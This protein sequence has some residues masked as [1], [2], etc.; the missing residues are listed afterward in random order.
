MIESAPPRDAAEAGRRV[1]RDV[2]AVAE[3][4]SL[5]SAGARGG[6]LAEALRLAAR[7]LRAHGTQLE[8]LR[9]NASYVVVRSRPIAGASAPRSCSVSR[10]LLD[11]L[12]QLMGAVESILIESRCAGRGAEWCLY[13]V[14]LRSASDLP[15]DSPI[16]G[17]ADDDAGPATG[18]EG[19]DG[20]GV[21]ST[22]DVTARSLDELLAEV[23]SGE[24]PV[25]SGGGAAPLK[26][27]PEVATASAVES[28]VERDAPGADGAHGGAVHGPHLPARAAWARR[29]AWPAAAMAV[30]GLLG[31]VAADALRS[32]SATATT[33]L[34]VRSGATPRSPGSAQD[35]AQ[36]AV[37]YAALIP[38]DTALAEALG[39]QLGTSP[40][41]ARA[42]LSVTALS[43]TAL[44]SLSYSAPKGHEAVA[45]ARAA[46]RLLTR[47]RPPGTALV[48]GSIAVVSLPSSAS[49]GSLGPKGLLAG[50]LAGLF[51]GLL[52]ILLLERVDAR[53]D[54]ATDLS[55][56]SGCPATA[57]PGAMSVHELSAA[58][59]KAAPGEAVTFV[60]TSPPA[61]TSAARLAELIASS[62]SRGGQLSRVPVVPPYGEAAWQLSYG[63]GPTVLVVAPGERRR[64]VADVRARLGLLG[65]D[66]VF[67]VLAVPDGARGRGR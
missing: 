14:V 25:S 7:P 39:S 16:S 58:L 22:E 36:L 33:L 46:A 62:P 45:G 2:A 50:L 5:G 3:R 9:S 44:V 40:A 20:P 41:A 24:R 38:K 19:S 56:S 51:V 48:P 8:L 55:D 29:R 57:V 11:T 61:S 67:G 66:P 32:P 65:R 49:P 18:H 15:P 43:G 52:L 21:S 31:G 27:L 60:P 42:A 54:D 10:G 34:V 13:S 1:A 12:P 17:P 47:A 64:H 59:A 35:A 6:A 28:A 26:D 23:T 37:T 4:A 53:V 30:I 63:A